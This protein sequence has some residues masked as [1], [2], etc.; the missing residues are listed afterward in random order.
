MYRGLTFLL[1]VFIVW[2]LQ[3][4]NNDS[5]PYWNSNTNLVPWRL[6]MSGDND[7]ISYL[8][9]DNDGDP[10]V[11]FT[12]IFGDIPVMWI[13]DNDNMRYGDTQGDMYGDCL[14]IDRNKD[15]KWAGPRDLCIKWGDENGDMLPDIQL[16]VSNG[17]EKKL[18]YFDWD[19]DFIYMIDFGEKDGIFNYIDWNTIRLMCW[20]HIGHANFFSDY[21][22]NNLFLKMHG[23]PYHIDNISYNWE[24]PFIFYDYDNDGLT[25]FT[26]RLVDTPNFRPKNGS[27]DIFDDI[28]DQYEISFTK[29]IDWVAFSWDLDNDNTYGKEFDFDMSVHF[30]GEGFDYSDQKHTFNSLK[31]LESANKLLW[32]DSWRKNVELIYA[33]QNA[34]FDL[35]FDRGNNKYNECWF[36]FDEDDD[37]NRWERVE[38][39]EPKD[40]YTIGLRKGG[41]DNNAQSDAIGDR[42]EW[43]LDNSGN[44]NLYVS[45]FDGRLHLY[46]AEWGCWRIDQTAYCYQ[47]F[48]GLYDK[49]AFHRMTEEPEIFGLV[50][51][52]DTDKNGFIDLI[53]Y[54]LD[55]NQDFEE[56]VS[57]IDLGIDD[58]C[59]IIELNKQDYSE[60]NRLFKK[61]AD[62]MWNK[63][64][65]VVEKAK[66]YQ[67]TTEWYSFY[68]HPRSDFEKYSH[69]YWL[70]FYLYKDMRHKALIADDTE[71]V[72]NLDFAYYSNDWSNLNI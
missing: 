52:T 66:L 63:A 69:G 5:I 26:I 18:G 41:I 7:D 44:G 71:M 56:K 22:G 33:D 6:P 60:M 50:K 55:G 53:E 3:A 19:A 68:M 13:D 1:L 59:N 20:S 8:D 36:V 70:A 10:D 28:D 31:G 12:T 24:N 21:H 49:W 45:K 37:C 58:T 23:S 15:G 67:I 72:H 61:V 4:I 25:E 48:G 27:S 62:D 43:D 11:L 65:N 17:T 38:F 16:V 32:D 14:V 39:Y 42:G 46:G 35:V 2:N 30:R 29:K 64:M 47:G 57:L 40:L 34:A 54:D 51:Y 9:L